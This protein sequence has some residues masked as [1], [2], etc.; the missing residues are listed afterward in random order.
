[1]PAK[2][3]KTAKKRKRGGR[4]GGEVE[5]RCAEETVRG[6][7]DSVEREKEESE[8]TEMERSAERGGEYRKG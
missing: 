2:L 6:R 1:M 5:E 8:M 7:E 3:N 4:Y